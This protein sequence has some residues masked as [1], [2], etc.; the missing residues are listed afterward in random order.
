MKPR[1]ADVLAVGWYLMTPPLSHTVRFEVDN[2]APL[3]AW[4]II[5]SF[6]KAEN[7]EDYR[8]HELEKYRADA[9]TKPINVRQTFA[10]ALLF[11][12]CIASDDPRLK[13][14]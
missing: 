9:V 2:N 8:S 6:D 11:S 4:T 5:R 13:S 1:H 10:T 12:Q 7:C 3:S 14:K